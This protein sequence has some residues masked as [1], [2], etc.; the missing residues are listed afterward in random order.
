[1]PSVPFATRPA[2][3]AGGARLVARATGADGKRPAR[4]NIIPLRRTDNADSLDQ[5]PMLRVGDGDRPAPPPP[6]AE[7]RFH[8]ALILLASLIV[9]AASFAFFRA[10][11]KM[12]ASVGEDAI[13]VEIVVGADAAAGIANARSDIEAEQQPAMDAPQDETVQTKPTNEEAA[14]RPESALKPAEDAI[15]AVQKE[16]VPPERNVEETPPEPKPLEPSRPK[17]SPSTASAPAASSIGRGRM[18]GDANYQ[19]LIAARL[20]R[21]KRFPPEARRRREHGSALVS[22]TI[23][24]KGRVTLVRLVRGTGFAALDDE[25]QAMVRRASPF[26]PPPR[27]AEMNFSA[28]VSFHLN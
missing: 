4:A 13:T 20:A 24:G 14:I 10:E 25:A 23:D 15:A 1:M 6:Y 28:P 17:P 19:G 22:F 3:L 7:K 12:T 2:P 21:F 16:I 26:P 11:P 27:G 18:A 8:L 5:A 9:H